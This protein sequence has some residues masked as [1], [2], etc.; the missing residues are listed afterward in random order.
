VPPEGPGGGRFAAGGLLVNIQIERNRIRDMGLCG[1][2]PVGFFDLRQTLEVISIENLTI[3]GNEITATLLSPVAAD[4]KADSGVGYGA[5]CVPDVANLVVCDNAIT[6]F[7]QTPAAAVCGIFILHAEVAEISRNQVRQ[8]GAWISDDYEEAGASG[9][10]AGILALAVTPPPLDA[11]SSGSQWT[12]ASGAAQDALAVPVYQPGLPAVRVEHNV[13]QVAVG[14]AL[15]II[16]LGP[17]SVVNN[18]LSSG[19][20]ISLEGTSAALTVLILN[21]SAAMRANAAASLSGLVRSAESD[22]KETDRASSRSPSSGSV[23]FTNNIC[24]LETRAGYQRGLSSVFVASLDHVLFGDNACWVDGFKPC[25]A[26]DALVLART[27]QVT[28]NRFQ[29]SGESVFDSCLSLGL[30][31]I[32]TQNISDNP[33]KVLA[34]ASTQID[35]QN[36]IAP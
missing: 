18:S 29:E 24:Q 25:A 36:L 7:G 32:T 34:P 27:V 21:L 22:Q 13:V 10:R 23:L 14:E 5:I 11:A 30:A 3:A 6:D 9:V 4:D 15:E 16:G 33:I 8:E 20:T 1:I 17:F 28:S 26:F 12:T 19:G 2:G 35:S 31:N